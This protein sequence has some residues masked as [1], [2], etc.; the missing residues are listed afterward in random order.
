M[1][2]NYNGVLNQ[3][4]VY[5]TLRNMIISQQTF[6]DNIAGVAS[7]LVDKA[8]V[9]G[10]IY[11]DTKLYISTDVLESHEWEGD[12][13]AANLLAIDR[14]PEPKVQSIV[15]NKFR[16][17]RVTT[18]D[19]LS[20]RA[21]LTEN[22]FS[23]FTAVILAWLRDTKRVYDATT[24]AA[25]FGTHVSSGAKQQVSVDL[26]TAGGNAS[27]ELEKVKLQAMEFGR[28][29][30]DLLVEMKDVSRDFN[31]FGHLRS[32]SGEAIKIVW[33]SKYYNK[34]RKVDLP[35]IFHN[36]GIIE[37]F[38]SD[39]LS[40]KYF[41]TVITSSNISSFS[42]ST[43]A[44]G[45]PID[46]DDGTYTPGSNNANGCIRSLVEKK[47][48][49][50]DVDYHI[51]PGME[52]PAGATIVASTG[53]WLP[54]EVYIEQGD[55]IAKIVVKYPPFMSAFEVGSEFWNPRSHTRNNYLTFSH[56]TLEHLAG[57][58]FITVKAI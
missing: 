28:A 40:S 22:V 29:L 44:A 36:E 58:P 2:I 4:E 50:S 14:A 32:Y 26:T 7:S 37:K 41:G 31:D 17:I 25:W 6:A 30:A 56:N 5:S 55:V 53:D 33:N 13:E 27:T 42:A 46:S 34:L 18:D 19:L 43:P 16:Q 45:K 20:K 15:L 57:Y 8:R 49:I 11:G 23:E 51:F 54:G 1:P 9:D 21:F 24:Y 38:D 12:A 47:V 52:L 3:S 10:G 35:T 39:V 48:K